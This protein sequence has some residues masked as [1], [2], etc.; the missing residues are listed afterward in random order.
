MLSQFATEADLDPAQANILRSIRG[1]VAS[2]MLNFQPDGGVRAAAV[3]N[4]ISPSLSQLGFSTGAA[5]T[6]VD[7]MGTAVTVH[8]GRAYMN[9]EAVWRI[10]QLAGDPSIRAVITVVPR[11]YK[12]SACASKVAAQ[13]KALSANEGVM[14][15]LDW[16]SYAPFDS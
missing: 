16:A 1:C 12:G 11:V 5:G 7:E 4:A 9:N 14:V 10:I 8:G 3:R 13:I 15:D 6:L 2:A